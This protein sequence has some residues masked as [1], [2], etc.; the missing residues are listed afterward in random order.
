MSFMLIIKEVLIIEVSAKNN[1]KNIKSR[2]KCLKNKIFISTVAF[3]FL[4]IFFIFSPSIKTKAII[5]PIL[6]IYIIYLSTTLFY[7]SIALNIFLL[8][9]LPTILSTNKYVFINV[10]NIDI[11]FVLLLSIFVFSIFNFLVLSYNIKKAFSDNNS[12]IISFIQKPFFKIFAVF[13]LYITLVYSIIDSFAIL[14]AHLSKVFNEGIVAKEEAITHVDSFY[15]STTTFFTIGLGDFHP[16]EYSELTKL[17]VIIQA[18]LS[19]IVSV[20]LWPVSIIFLFD[21]N[22]KNNLDLN[23]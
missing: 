6:S 13:I 18:V 10:S 11:L 21:K 4:L 17:L 12:K 8:L 19:H 14:Y 3:I 22:R 7:L 1:K 16:S 2:L 9:Y 20:V 15:F 23:Q 5:A